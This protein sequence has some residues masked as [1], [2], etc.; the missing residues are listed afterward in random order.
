M[1]KKMNLK[2]L[3]CNWEDIVKDLTKKKNGNNIW[4][5]V[6]RISLTEMVYCIWMERNQRIFRGEKRNAVNLYTAINE[7]VHL[8]LMNIKVKD[9]CVVKKVADTWGIQFKSID[10]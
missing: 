7:V 1:A 3:C 8:K 5:D 10:C 4:S 6:K 9:S 2:K